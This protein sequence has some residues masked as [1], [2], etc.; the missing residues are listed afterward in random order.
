MLHYITLFYIIIN[1]S[2]KLKLFYSG[3]TLHYIEN[4]IVGQ[5]TKYI[6]MFAKEQH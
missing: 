4:L 3:F 1:C 6:T 5:A 2:I